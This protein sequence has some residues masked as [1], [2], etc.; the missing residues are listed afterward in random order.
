MANRDDL[1]DLL[2]ISNFLSASDRDNN[3]PTKNKSKEPAAKNEDLVSKDVMMSTKGFFPL[4]TYKNLSG[5][6]KNNT[7]PL[8]KEKWKRLPLNFVN[9]KESN[10]KHPQ[11][12]HWVPESQSEKIFT[13]SKFNT[14]IDMIKYTNQEYDKHLLTLNDFWTKPETD[15]LWDLLEKYH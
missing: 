5:N 7:T 10:S 11:I 1:K 4:R 9:D 8:I 13:F 3:N 6:L 2:S 12:S 14:K 15:Y